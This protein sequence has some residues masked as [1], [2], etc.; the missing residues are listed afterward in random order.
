M[1]M[2]FVHRVFIIFIFYLLIYDIYHSSFNKIATHTHIY[3]YLYIFSGVIIS[4]DLENGVKVI[5]IKEVQ[6]DEILMLAQDNRSS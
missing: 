1:V 3:I 5:K 6:G 2:L 4:D